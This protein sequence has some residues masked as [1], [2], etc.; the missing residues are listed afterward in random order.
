MTEASGCLIG[1]AAKITPHGDVTYNNQIIRLLQKRCVEC[2]RAGEVAPF[3]LVDYHEVVGWAPMMREV[4]D[5]GRMPPW[6]A[7]PAHGSFANDVRL[8]AEE[9]TLFRTWVDNGC[10]KAMPETCRRR[11]TLPRVGKWCEPDQVIYMR[12]EPYAVPAEG[13][14]AY[15]Y[16]VVDPHFTEDKWVQAAE[17]RPGNRGAV[18]HMIAFVQA[19]P[20]REKT[21]NDFRRG[22]GL[23]GY[24]PGDRARIYPPGV[25]A[26]IPAGSKFIFQMHYTPNGTKQEDRSYIGLK[27]ADPS[28]VKRRARGGAAVNRR[29]TIQP[30]A[31]NQ[32]VKALYTFDRDTLLATLFPHMHLRGKSFSYVA[33]YPNGTNEIL[34]D[35][36][37]YDFNWQLRY[38]LTEPKLMPRGTVLECVAHFD[39]SEDNLANP[40]PKAPVRWGD[41]AF[42]EMM[43][44]FF[45][46]LPVT[47]DVSIDDN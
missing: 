21:G 16:F 19:P 14:V 12:D 37:H 28:T 34:L 9:K 32:E 31:Q 15:Q 41:Q 29:F 17:A 38:V 7:D 22:G 24:T 39:N 36:P 42:E 33:R 26:Y 3:A 18:H 2:H 45:S 20:K 27:F 5:E 8:T 10:P 11:R 46:T 40:N 23:V 35:V 6:F 44:G 43:I 1:R 13:V 47:D 30:G 4:I 25:A